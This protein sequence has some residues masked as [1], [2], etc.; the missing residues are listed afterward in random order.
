MYNMYIDIY[1]TLRRLLLAHTK[2]IQELS[3]T[4]LIAKI[5]IGR[6]FLLDLSKQANQTNSLPSDK[7]CGVVD[8]WTSVPI[9]GGEMF[10]SL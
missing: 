7:V 2:R 10:K 8:M 1:N 6:Q 3:H 9:S 5:F 4:C